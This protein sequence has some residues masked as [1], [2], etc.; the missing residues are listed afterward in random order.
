M[1]KP[2]ILFHDVEKG[3]AIERE[4]TDTEYAQYLKDEEQLKAEYKKQQQKENLRISALE[5]LAAL[6]L[7]E[8]EIAAL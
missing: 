2:I 7:T 6:G 1:K 4:M 8:D 3:E 5:K